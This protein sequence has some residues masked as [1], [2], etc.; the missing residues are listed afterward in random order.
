MLLDV[1]VSEKKMPSTCCCGQCKMK[2]AHSPHLGSKVVG[3]GKKKV[4][5][6]FSQVEKCEDSVGELWRSDHSS[7]GHLLDAFRDI[8]KTT[9]LHPHNDCWRANAV[10]CCPR[11]S[12]GKFLLNSAD[13]CRPALLKTI[14]ELQPK[15]II[16]FGSASIKALY[17]HRNDSFET[18]IDSW[19]GFE[20]PDT[21]LNAWVLPCYDIATLAT[22]T[23][24][25]KTGDFS[26][27]E[28]FKIVERAIAHVLQRATKLLDKNLPNCLDE[29]EKLLR[30]IKKPAKAVEALKKIKSGDIIS[31]D[32]ETSGTKPDFH[33]H[34]IKCAS[35]CSKALGTSVSFLM[36][37][38]EP[39]VYAEV[40]KEWKRI[41]RDK[42]IRKIGHNIK[43]EDRW[44]KKWLGYRVLGWY[45][46]TM[47]TTHALYSSKKSVT[48]LKFQVAV[49][50]GVV[51]YN[52]F[53]E[54]CF[55]RT[56]ANK[57]YGANAVNG[58][59]DI[60]V[61][62]LLHYCAQDSVFTFWLWKKQYKQIQ[63][64]E[65][66]LPNAE[67]HQS[68]VDFLRDSILTF[69]KMEER[70]SKIDVDYLQIQLDW[71][72]KEIEKCRKEFTATPL[73]RK[74]RAS[75]LVPNLTSGKQL[76]QLL[77]TTLGL[78]QKKKTESGEDSTDKEALLA[79]GLPDLVP[80]F[81]MRLLEKAK[82]TYIKQIMQE[83]NPEDNLLHTS[84]TLNIAST[85]RSTSKEPNLQNTPIRNKDIGIII[86]GAF[87]SR[88]GKDGVLIEAD[89]KGAEVS[90]AAC[91]NK[92][93]NFIK[94]VTDPK[95]DMH[96]DTMGLIMMCP[97]ANIVKDLRHVAK[98]KFVFP[99]FYGDWY[100]TCAES[101]WSEIQKLKM[102]DGTPALLHLQQQDL[103]KLPKKWK[104]GLYL[105][106]EEYPE[107]YMPFEEHM[108]DVEDKF[109]NEMFPVYTE[110]K[111]K[112]FKEYLRKGYVDS[113]TGF[114]YTGILDKKKTIN[115]PIQ[116]DAYHVNQRG[117]NIIDRELTVQKF[118]TLITNQIHDSGIYD[119]HVSEFKDVI[120]L[121]N[122]TMNEKIRRLYPWINVPIVVEFEVSEPGRSW[123]Y[124]KPFDI[125]TM[126]FVS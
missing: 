68:G 91:Y 47:L 25:S 76:G 118:I 37:T 106:Q 48:G 77:Y 7:S 43:H 74:W 107:Q 60:P 117:I 79:L 86:R 87:I 35:V 113:F 104:E 30:V 123:F 62:E 100:K 124:K 67:T 21:E 119:S 1:P 19:H 27:K 42:T 5:L 111:N 17:S 108:K 20:I 23:K 121:I 72:T 6:V 18:N 41:L 29:A 3:K 83:V 53:V 96:K 51:H 26:K 4:L 99:Q 63:K 33:G 81:R 110:W 14:K 69:S 44:S 9:D 75:Q 40:L 97:P 12:E 58:I 15:V 46:D 92:D 66:E 122:T 39:V 52:N 85:F 90:V 115:Y 78:K 10:H 80:L 112:W 126:K 61:T 105:P 64:W 109:W 8:F 114:R 16:A 2:G 57:K 31:F 22:Q 116:G 103:F 125:H 45:W 82:G 71:C 70:G 98:N 49:N 101:I 95:N 11:G 38:R 102:A 59:D 50:F 13:L 94:Y 73:Y 55:K 88:H 89:L 120:K 24:V 56:V 65:N 36:D 93:P 32:Y 34:F 28:T 84:F 54:H